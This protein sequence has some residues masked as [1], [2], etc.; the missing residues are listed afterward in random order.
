MYIYGKNSVK[1]HLATKSPIK[2]II[3]QDNFK[4]QDIL[5]K[6]PLGVEVVKMNGKSIEKLLKEKA[7]H[8]GVIL[9]IEDYRY[10][11]LKEL[12]ASLEGLHNPLLLI[13]DGVQDP[14]N[15]GAII[16]TCDAMG[17]VGIILPTNRSV[18]VTSTV[19]KVS[20]GAI[21]HVSI[22]MVTNLTRT[23]QE[24]KKIGFWIVGAE[25]FEAQDY[26]SVDYSMPVAV[27]MGSE[28]SGISRLVLEQC[29]FKVKLP[30]VGHVNSLNVSVATAVLLYQIYN[31]RN[32]LK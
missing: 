7:L 11:S 5:A 28:G 26:R 27:V 10:L 20:T 6:L 13:L 17:V 19:I 32:P 12:I 25:A 9:E 21:D 3:L 29:D 1:M 4:D 31:N 24:L 2:K 14:H 22:A 18:S 23:I 16:R 30:M 15:L 8:Q